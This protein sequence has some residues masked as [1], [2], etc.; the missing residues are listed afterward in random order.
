MVFTVTRDGDTTSACSVDYYT[1]N[2]TAQAG[3]DYD[4]VS[5][6]LNFLPN[7]MTKIVVVQIHGDKTYEPDEK[8]FLNL[9][10]PG[11]AIITDGQ[12]VGTIINDD[13]APTGGVKISIVADP[14]DPTKNALKIV[15]TSS[16][17]T[18]EVD[19]GSQQGKVTV[20]INGT[21]KGTFN[22][23]GH[24]LVY[25]GAGNDTI[26]I[27]NSITRA[28]YV[29]GEAGNDTVTA[30]GGNDVVLGGD[31]NDKL[32]GR[33]GRD[34]LI[35]DAGKDALTGGNGDDL[36]VGGTTLYDGD[37]GKL[38]KIQKEWVRTDAGYSTRV[39]DLKNG[40]GLNGS[41]KLNATT[42]FGS[43]SIHDSLTGN[44]GSDLFFAAVPGDS[45]TDKGGSETVIDVG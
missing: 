44:S 10:A 13:P 23:T 37:L 6:T 22:F 19:H 34:I 20:K 11:N 40:G 1:S 14:I 17:D 21:S 35:G 9:A 43:S 8:F 33:D 7:Q 12:A 15:G 32:L 28:A 4:A 5:G 29:F 27:D 2:G 18:I 42:A 26:T 25:G 3:S 16:A 45:L 41:V 39:T 24:I 38:A 30:G 36:L 31:G